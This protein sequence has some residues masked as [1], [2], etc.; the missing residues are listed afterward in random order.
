MKNAIQGVV[1]QIGVDAVKKS[2][3]IGFKLCTCVQHGMYL[4][5]VDKEP[6]CPVCQQSDNISNEANGTSATDV[7]HYVN[8]GQELGTNPQQKLSPYG[9]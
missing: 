6:V 8:P 9:L 1:D 7:E 2:V 5:A 3:G 4:C